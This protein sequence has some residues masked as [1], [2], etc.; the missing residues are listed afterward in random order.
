MNAT[1]DLIRDDRCTTALKPLVEEG[2]NRLKTFIV[3]ASLGD[4]NNW[5]LP[6]VGH[7]TLNLTVR[8]GNIVEGT[9]SIQD[10]ENFTV[11]AIVSG[12]TGNCVAVIVNKSEGPVKLYLNIPLKADSNPA[13]SALCEMRKCEEQQRIENVATRLKNLR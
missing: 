7:A 10:G 4:L 1:A 3:C 8:D 13:L 2:V 5:H 11:K 6:K 9:I 12:L